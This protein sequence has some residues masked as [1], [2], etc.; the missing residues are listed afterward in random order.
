MNKLQATIYH[1]VIEPEL[2]AQTKG[3]VYRP[4]NLANDGFVHC[5]QKTSV[6]P[7]A[8]DYYA[9]VSEKLLLLEIDPTKLTQEVRF[10]AAAPIPGGGAAHLDSA[11]HF[12]H[13]YGPIDVAAISGVG[14]LGH[15]EGGYA[16]PDGFLSFDSFMG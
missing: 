11:E 7:V 8:N 9:E 6:V 13:V 3:D 15:G 2:R 10:E 14:V 16:W 12:P 1:L 4:V 5:S